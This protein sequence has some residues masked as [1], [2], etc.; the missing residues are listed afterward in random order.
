MTYRRSRVGSVLVLAV[1]FAVTALVFAWLYQL[2]G[3]RTPLSSSYQ[4]AVVL[5]SGYTLDHGADVRA[6]GVRI[7]RVI[8]VRPSGQASRITMEI[9]ER[10][11]PLPR[12]STVRLRTRTLVGENALDVTI[13]DPR[14]GVVGNGGTLPLSAA[15]ESVQIDQV[16]RTLSPRTRRQVRAT[17]HALAGATRGRGG[18]LNRTLASAR[19]L[20]ASGADVARVL[21]AQDRQVARVLADGAT[22]L[23]ALGD[24]EQALRG[25]IA[26][27]RTAASA[28]SARDARLRATLARLP[29]TLTSARRGAAA[30]GA[31]G[32][33]GVRVLEDLT[34]ASRRLTPT[35]RALGPAARDA[36]RLTRRLPAL[37]RSLTPL[38]TRLRAFA[39]RARPVVAPLRSVLRHVEPFARTLAPY[40][41][42]LGAW[43]ANLGAAA[44]V[45]DANGRAL[46]V[47][48]VFD[49]Q[50]LAGG[51]PAR[52][53]ALVD[54]VKDA[55][56][57]DVVGTTSV[58][59]YPAPGTAGR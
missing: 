37:A 44:D 4:V 27:A 19:D 28:V 9:D 12:D 5:P 48:L 1:F 24:R 55:S 36:R 8:E 22:V 20:T 57:V 33:T 30:L 15:E 25:L 2:A 53:Q 34:V 17:L 54:R 11:A 49:E 16:L 52:L 39:V 6:A 13:G 26:D 51:L 50:T 42:D 18:D 23:D 59:P 14:R 21:A 3:G 41:R 31:L 38:L 10:Q 29:R 32:R 58:D 35:I 40:G 43:F 46:R 45:F 56:P 47:Q 7:G